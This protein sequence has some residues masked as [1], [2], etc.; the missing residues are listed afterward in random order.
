M[1]AL[2]GQQIEHYQVRV[3]LGVGGM[4]A[5]YEAMDLKLARAVALKVIQ[6]AL[7]RNAD[8][9]RRFL[10][11]AQ[12][13]AALNHPGI[14]SIYDFQAS[15]E[16]VYLTMNYITGGS[17]GVRMR[18]LQGQ[19]ASMDAGEAVAIG[20]L[21]ADALHH[22][23]E[24]GVVHQDLKPNAILLRPDAIGDKIRDEN[25]QILV[26]DFG[27]A[28]LMEV[29]E[30][31]QTN[32]LVGTLAYMAPEQALGE[33]PT[34]LSDIYS[35]GVCLYLMSTGR[36]PFEI[37]SIYDAV[38]KHQYEI[39]PAPIELVPDLPQE[40]SD[41]IMQA[42]SKNPDE[43]W[44]NGAEF[45]AAL[46]QVPLA[47]ASPSPSVFGGGSFD[48]SEGPRVVSPT[49]RD[50]AQESLF[51]M[52]DPEWDGLTRV[53][54]ENRL[55]V[56]SV[57]TPT[58]G[59]A[60]KITVSLTSPR[61]HNINKD[62][63][64]IGRDNG[65]DITLE[66]Q[67]VSL[68][69]ATLN[70]ARGGSRWE[71][72]DLGS[73]N[74]VFLDGVRLLPDV[75][76]PWDPTQVIQVGP[77]Y[78]QLRESTP[79]I[80]APVSDT[81]N[82][83]LSQTKIE[84]EPGDQRELRVLVMN[85]SSARDYVQL[86]LADLPPTWFTFHDTTQALAPGQE[87]QVSILL[88]PP[89]GEEIGS[90]D[91]RFRV[92]A[93]SIMPTQAP[94]ILSATLSIP[95][96]T[97]FITELTP[98]SVK[99]SFRSKTLRLAL[100]NR[101]TETAVFNVVGRSRDPDAPDIQFGLT[102]YEE[103]EIPDEVV[104][105]SSLFRADRNLSETGLNGLPTE[106]EPLSLWQRLR[107]REKKGAA[108][109]T[110]MV[111]RDREKEAAALR[112]AR[113]ADEKA[114][115]AAV[116]ERAQRDFV[117]KS[118]RIERKVTSVRY[119]STY[120]DRISLAPGQE[121]SVDIALKAQP[122]LVGRKKTYPLEFTVSTDVYNERVLASEVV[123]D[124]LVRPWFL[125]TLISLFL[126]LFIGGLS[127]F[128]FSSG[129]TI[130]VASRL[131]V[132]DIDD[133]GLGNLRE[134]Y[135]L[136]TNPNAA[137]TDGDGLNDSKELDIN[138]NPNVADT[139]QDGLSD[140]QEEELGT[141]PLNPDSDNDSF[142]DGYEFQFGSNPLSPNRDRELY[143]VG[144]ET[145]TP[146]P[147]PTPTSLPIPT[148]EPQPEFLQIILT[149]RGSE[150]GTVVRREVDNEDG[151]VTLPVLTEIV[152]DEFIQIGDSARSDSQY[153]G[154]LS[155]N[156]ADVPDDISILDVSLVLQQPANNSAPVTLG[157]LYLD[158]SLASGFSGSPLLEKDDFNSS[159]AAIV[160]YPLVG[161]L[162]EPISLG[163]EFVQLMREGDLLQF[164][165]YYALT[166]D[167]NGV[168]DTVL[169]YSGDSNDQTIRPQLII[170]YEE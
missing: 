37:H 156:V 139:D 138:T 53:S 87:G 121:T 32:P 162:N 132:G 118:G 148:P 169:I 68:F 135:G 77:Y 8:F 44:Q 78:L 119:E 84:V 125:T 14:V 127:Y 20:A 51:D 19:G 83:R 167:G 143:P 103:V 150:D 153:K 30:G 27:F 168:E 99:G 43:R 82:V 6:P 76:E 147:A 133:D 21:V 38:Q 81:L 41:I 46:R 145:A 106:E 140:G 89:Q 62:I 54:V 111:E 22:A 69:H 166:N 126:L 95:K 86:E 88:H 155:F 105:R 157:E 142:P 104:S 59:N 93:T 122:P 71:I 163:R 61:I 5:V 33:R 159:T 42:L 80:L 152:V 13:L 129:D 158:V 66:S 144:F 90:E 98:T 117:L 72:R 47:T 107:S 26:A 114:R 160:S 39:P 141:D 23:H 40:L 97:D 52:S 113:Q 58:D 31:D 63:V 102:E 151:S 57:G 164:R 16:I 45:A 11:E 136:R 2:V 146:V 123:I 60:D 3:F 10:Q 115:V 170:A 85:N 161:P 48:I 109:P 67:S 128:V 18:R 112:K 65:N 75:P 165:L 12:T 116:R 64:T 70:R 96:R 24:K 73:A 34:P 79:S 110:D 9:R 101:G 154:F 74:G 134:M 55:Q 120:I 28:S 25:G 7:A 17:V 1:D 35:L 130:A 124:P 91:R 149:S 36:H 92:I 56:E 4:A 131:F 137:D 50:T 108:K 94:I 100:R 15:D 29:H 49:D